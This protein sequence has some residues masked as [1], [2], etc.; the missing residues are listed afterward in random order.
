MTTHL[1]WQGPR[2]VHSRTPSA[3]TGVFGCDICKEEK[4]VLIFDTSEMEYE[5]IYLCRE[6][7]GKLWNASD[8]WEKHDVL[9]N[10]N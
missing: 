2:S 5:S 9:T 8:A 7:V 1:I 4:R 10:E 6:C 3:E